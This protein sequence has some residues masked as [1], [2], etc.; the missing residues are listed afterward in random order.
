MGIGIARGLDGNPAKRARCAVAFAPGQFHFLALLAPGWHFGG[1]G[2]NR[3]RRQPQ[4]FPGSAIGVLLQVV[5]AGEAALALEDLKR[6]V[7]DVVLN[8]I[9]LAG[10]PAQI[11]HVLVLDGAGVAYECRRVPRSRRLLWT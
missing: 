5:A 1:N 9:R 11:G 8:Q 6:E 7:V 4:A 3:L 10:R 2:L